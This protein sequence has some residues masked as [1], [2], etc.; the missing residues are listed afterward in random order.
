MGY[1]S[2]RLRAELTPVGTHGTFDVGTHRPTA[3]FSLLVLMAL[4]LCTTTDVSESWFKHPAPKVTNVNPLRMHGDSLGLRR[5][6]V[7]TMATVF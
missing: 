1:S 6:V 7:S 5:V 4:Y 2:R 3:I